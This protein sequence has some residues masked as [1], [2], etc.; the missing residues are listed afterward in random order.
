M[1]AVPFELPL[2]AG[3]A[4]ALAELIFHVTEGRALTDEVRSRVAA[5]G[6]ALGLK[7]LEPYYGSLEADPVHSSTYYIATDAC[8]SAVPCSLLLHIAPASAPASSVFANPLLIGRMRPGGRREV[9]VNAIPFSSRDH[10]NIRKFAECINRAF[11]PR[12]QGA[13]P[14]IAAGNRHPEISLAAVFDAY[15]IILRK[16][17]VNM[18]STAQLSATRE[19]TTDDAI[20][21]R[22]GEN[23]TAAG[24]TRVS[25][26]HLYHAGVWAAIR[27]G[28]REGYNAEAD[29]FIITGETDEQV[30]R[31]I[32]ATKVAIRDAAA[33]TKFTTDTSRLF[34]LQADPRHPRAWSDQEVEQ[35]FE[36][37]FT[38]EERGWVIDEFSRGFEIGGSEYSFSFGDVARLAVKFGESLKINEELFDEIRAAKAASPGR[39]FD[40]EPSLDEAETLTTPK[41][42]IFY[43]HWL[44]QRGRAAQ[45]VPPNLGFKKRQAYPEAMKSG[46]ESGIGLEDYAKHKMWP[47]LL[48]RVEGE[49]GGRPLEELGARVSELAAVAR[50][51]NGTLSIHSGSGKQAEVLEQIGRATSG[52]V[53]YKISG[54]LQLQMFDVLRE[55]SHES[56]WRRLYDRMVARCEAFAE[57]GCFGEESGLAVRFREMGRGSSLGDCRRGRVDGNLFLVFWLGNIVGSRDIQSP[58]GDHRFFKEKLDE[59]PSNLVRAVRERNTDYVVWLASHLRP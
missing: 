8:G 53:N 42:L 36:E 12:P 18:A 11:F 15:R 57:A 35:R 6:A 37:I 7:S 45:L 47:E 23:P 39:T 54:E 40:F 32:E 55:Q 31:S 51:F 9:V 28:W 59:L 30:R 17:S 29:H 5:R 27:S 50:H 22:D 3:E 43:M 49:F 33:Y 56:P 21:A 26:R 2:K 4:S 16:Y 10:E 48:P 46:A 13:L 41:E 24:H 19:M 58:D 25:I 20:A 52:R 1:T 38:A 34:R 44:K 14:A